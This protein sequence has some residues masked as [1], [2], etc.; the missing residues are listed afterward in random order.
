MN[1]IQL[2]A[3]LVSLIHTCQANP[4]FYWADASCS[5]IQHWNTWLDETFQMARGVYDRLED[6]DQ[7]MENAFR[8]IFGV[9]PADA[10]LFRHPE[11]FQTLYVDQRRF[12]AIDLVKSLHS[13]MLGISILY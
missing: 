11:W 10:N 1:L 5:D 8:L 7:D 3:A 2:I 13:S 12:T 4:L 9:E 6:N